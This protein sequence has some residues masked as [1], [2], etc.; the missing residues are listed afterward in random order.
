MVC[1]ADKFQLDPATTYLN[2]AYMAPLMHRVELAGRTAME[3]QRM[4]ST[5]GVDDFFVPPQQ[6]RE[7]FGELIGSGEPERVALVPSASYGLS[8]VANN[9]SLRTGDEILVVEGQFPSNIYP[10]LRAAQENNA[11]VSVVRAPETNHREADWNQA[12]LEHIGPRTA[13][14]AMGNIHW[15]DGTVFDL[16]TIGA[17]CRQFGAKLIIDGTQSVGALPFSVAEIQPDAVICAGYKWLLGSYGLGLAWFGECFDD[18]RP[19]EENWM[20]RKA[21][22]QFAGLVNYQSAYRPMAQRYNMGEASNFTYVAMLNEALD[23]LLQWGV[24]EVSEYA[25]R[26]T[27]LADEALVPFG[28]TIAPDSFRAP[29]LFGIGLPDRLNPHH[30]AVALKEQGISVSVRGSA[31]RVAVHVFNQPSDMLRLKD[32]LVALL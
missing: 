20:H 14:V 28:F 13:A 12:I 26:L 30:V 19:L 21:S 24:H 18:G 9:I 10:W 16:K 27:A 32:A 3:K 8:T 1:Q 22:D 15:A 7:R 31:V 4:P 17:R 6:L 25:R 29:H 5:L 23:Q 2:C 11:T